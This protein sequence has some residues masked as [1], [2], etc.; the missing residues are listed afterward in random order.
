MNCTCAAGKG[1]R[2]ACDIEEVEWKG[3]TGCGVRVEATLAGCPSRLGSGNW[4]R[5]GFEFARG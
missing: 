1:Y 4:Q 2:L 3:V 5:C